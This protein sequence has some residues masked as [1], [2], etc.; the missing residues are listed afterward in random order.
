MFPCN[1]KE[2]STDLVVAKL[3]KEWLY[4]N[5]GGLDSVKTLQNQLND[6]ETLL[7]PR[8]SM[9]HR[10]LCDMASVKSINFFNVGA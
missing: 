5:K 6:M 2:H 9:Y 3:K 7:I 10:W 8:R 1:A 4:R